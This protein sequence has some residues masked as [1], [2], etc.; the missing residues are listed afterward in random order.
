MT[1]HAALAYLGGR[2]G[3]RRQGDNR[4]AHGGL[5]AVLVEAAHGTPRSFGMPRAG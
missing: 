4:H 2:L 5:L 1:R 3:P